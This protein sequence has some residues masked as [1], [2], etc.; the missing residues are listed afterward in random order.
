MINIMFVSRM[1]H[2]CQGI[3]C[4]IRRDGKASSETLFL[5][6]L[7]NILQI[8]IKVTIKNRE[9]KL[10]EAHS[11]FT[12]FHISRKPMHIATLTTS[13][14]LNTIIQNI[15]V[16]SH[17]DQWELI[18][19]SQDKL[20]SS[21]MTASVSVM[22]KHVFPFGL[23]EDSLE[24]G[25]RNRGITARIPLVEN[26]LL[27]IYLCMAKQLLSK[28]QLFLPFL[29]ISYTCLKQMSVTVK[30]FSQY[31]K[32]YTCSKCSLVL[33]GSSLKTVSIYLHGKKETGLFLF[34]IEMNE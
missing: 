31:L 5:Y 4:K 3:N 28:I 32:F 9:F 24:Q 7:Q 21:R 8:C 6:S 10:K 18:F 1:L 11:L 20:S 30:W 17:S 22:Y 16:H 15:C 19:Y 13:V 14:T 12:I 29:P 33:T 2:L 23:R 27:A 26:Q 34:F 25:S